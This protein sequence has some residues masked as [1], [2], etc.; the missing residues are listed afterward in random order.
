MSSHKTCERSCC[1]FRL[2]FVPFVS[3]CSRIFGVKRSPL[4]A[5]LLLLV[6]TSWPAHSQDFVQ[7]HTPAVWEADDILWCGDVAPH[8]KIAD[9][10]D[11]SS[12]A[13]FEIVITYKRCI[14]LADIALVNSTGGIFERQSKYISSMSYRDVPKLAIETIIA[15]DPGVAFIEQQGIYTN[16]TDVS[17][18]A[19]RVTTSTNYAPNTVEDA[20]PTIDG[21]GVN[22][23]IMDRGVDDPGTGG[24]EH[25]AFN[26]STGTYCA[27]SQNFSNPNDGNG[28]GTHVAGI[29]LGMATAGTPRGVA[30]GAG[31]IDVDC[32]G[33]SWSV[34][35]DALEVTYDRRQRW[36]V[37]VINMSF[38]KFGTGASMGHGP[39][40]PDRSGF[41]ADARERSAD[42]LSCGH[43]QR[44]T[45]PL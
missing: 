27:F 21:S 19:I 16:M 25:Q 26:M 43:T 13:L 22:I 4:P 2:R 41:E 9:T 44:T 7:N 36:G 29:A 39:R 30:P 17:V 15:S 14:S 35:T 12:N 8:N 6:F 1:F 42:P 24:T 33:G 37:K 5:G 20:F 31:L 32:V 38:A 3:F 18:P 11:T 23:V 45:E 10:I 40:D 34:I 28:H